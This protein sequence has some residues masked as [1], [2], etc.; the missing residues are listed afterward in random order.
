MML[1]G[2]CSFGRGEA[3]PERSTPGMCRHLIVAAATAAPVLPALTTASASP[4][5]TRSTETLMEESF[6]CLTDFTAESCI[7]TISEACTISIFGWE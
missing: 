2:P 7:V 4:R 3:I 6:F 5:F 1:Q